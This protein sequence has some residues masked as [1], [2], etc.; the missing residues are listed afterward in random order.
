[1]CWACGFVIFLVVN[2]TTE[3]LAGEIE[4]PHWCDQEETLSRACCIVSSALFREGDENHIAPS[5]A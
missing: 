2:I 4:R 5:S 1:M 3:V